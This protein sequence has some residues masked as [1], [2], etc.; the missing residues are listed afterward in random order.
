[1]KRI[2]IIV[3]KCVKS[4]YR[5]QKIKYIISLIEVARVGIL[6]N[7]SIIYFSILNYKTNAYVN[8]Y[9]TNLSVYE[10]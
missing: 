7:N 8:A 1:M 9:L 5:S 2:I 6:I 4:K 3:P 10:I